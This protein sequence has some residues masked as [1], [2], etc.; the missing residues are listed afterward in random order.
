MIP[1]NTINQTIE[2]LVIFILLI[3]LA[4]THLR[5]SNQGMRRLYMLTVGLHVFNTLG[6]LYAWRYT[7]LQGKGMMLC[8]TLGN[9]FTYFIGPLAYLGFIFTVYGNITGRIEKDFI[10]KELL[11]T[12]EKIFLGMIVLLTICNLGLF[13]YNFFDP[14]IYQITAQNDFI[15]GKWRSVPDNLVML[16]FVLLLPPLILYDKRQWRQSFSMYLLYAGIPVSAILVESVYPTLMLLYPAVTLSLLLIYGQNYLEE[17]RRLMEK[18]VELSDSRVKLMM[19]QIQPHFIFNSLQAIQELCTENPEQ[20]EKSVHDFSQYLRGNLDA[21]SCTHLIPFEKELSHI[22]AYVALE[23]ADPGRTFEMIYDLE[24]T[25]FQ[26]PA[27]SIQ[28][29]VENAVKHGMTSCTKAGK[30]ILRTV[31]KPAEYTIQIIDNGKGLGD[32]IT[33]KQKERQR[34]G[35]ENVRTRLEVQCRGSLEIESSEAGV[36]VIIHIPKILE[37]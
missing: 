13:F 15:W 11:K 28:P 10:K 12:E 3:L 21:L 20:A 8:T 23:Q 14:V 26:V 27:L 4:I 7:G 37:D 19:G 6:D 22:Q 36:T 9:F 18:E 32:G 2:C 31:E 30:V 5:K 17:E 25:A 24:T 1:C 35:L 16:Q 33:Q 29:M 34:V